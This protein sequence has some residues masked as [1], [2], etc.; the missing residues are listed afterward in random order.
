MT[1]TNNAIFDRGYL[2]SGGAL[3]AVTSLLIVV[4]IMHHPVLTA[5]HGMTA[6]AVDMRSAARMDQIVHGSLMAIY[7][8]QTVGFYLFS[9]R[10][11][12]RNP[13]AAAGFLAFLAGALVMMIPATLDGFVTPDLAAA[14]IQAQ[15]GCTSS[16]AS[17]LRLVG[18]MIQNFTKLALV[19]ISVA[20]ACWSLPLLF[21]KG[22]AR[23]VAVIGLICAA[24]PAFVVVFYAVDLRPGNLTE[25]V[26]AQVVWNLAVAC[27]MLF[28][29]GSF[30]TTL[31]RER[32]G[33]AAGPT[34]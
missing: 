27:M 24:T 16:D 20:T 14:C 6:F 31:E 19:L 22:S 13:A 32:K 1:D 23:F 33:R 30:D 21:K 4:M 10:V 5:D 34:R 3:L 8:V 18:V 9:A 25:F 26:A 17:V 15:D 29:G 11:G 12:F 7:A 2:R 28:D